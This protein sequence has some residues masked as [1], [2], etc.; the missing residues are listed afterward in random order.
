MYN[1][2]IYILYMG[3]LPHIR[4]IKSYHC[5]YVRHIVLIEALKKKLMT[6][7]MIQQLYGPIYI[8]HVV[9]DLYVTCDSA[10]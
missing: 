8:G 1:G 4:C 7:T 6:G 10:F 5:P 2:M 9:S 3:W